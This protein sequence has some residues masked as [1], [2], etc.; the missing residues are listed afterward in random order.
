MNKTNNLFLFGCVL[1]IFKSLWIQK[2]W[3]TR[4]FTDF[5]WYQAKTTRL[6]YFIFHL[7]TL[8]NIVYTKQIPLKANHDS[9]SGN[10]FFNQG[11][12]TRDKINLHPEFSPKFLLWFI[13]QSDQFYYIETKIRFAVFHGNSIFYFAFIHFLVFSLCC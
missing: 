11:M 6:Q 4:N 5:V 8:W 13:P 1:L 9:F 3:S 12:L 7:I 2:A 10:W